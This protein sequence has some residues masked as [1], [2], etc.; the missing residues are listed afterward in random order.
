MESIKRQL[1]AAALGVQQRVDEIQ[2]EASVKDKTAQQWI[3]ILI[4]KARD[5]QKVRISTPETRDARLNGRL[6]PEK[7]KE[8]RKEIIAQIKRDIQRELIEWLYT[9]PSGSYEAIP[10]DS[11]EP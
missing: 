8:K 10:P 7:R 5:T 11:G 6:N 2:S 4:S 1:A 9:Q 3:E